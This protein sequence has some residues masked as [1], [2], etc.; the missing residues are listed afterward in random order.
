MPAAIAVLLGLLLVARPVADV[1]RDVR[2]E[3]VSER[4]AADDYGVVMAPDRTTADVEA[5]AALR[6]SLHARRTVGSAVS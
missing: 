4:A 1:V 2:D 6:H 5:T 3:I